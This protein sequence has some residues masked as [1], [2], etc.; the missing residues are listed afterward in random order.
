MSAAGEL[1]LRAENGWC[2]D[3]GYNGYS[4]GSAPTKKKCRGFLSWT[5]AGLV[6]EDPR[7]RVRPLCLLQRHRAPAAAE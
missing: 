7:V 5:R 3:T 1:V 2:F 4:S 6:A